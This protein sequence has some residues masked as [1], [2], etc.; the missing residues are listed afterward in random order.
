M[1]DENGVYRFPALPPGTYSVKFELS[2]FRPA[3][4][5]A[6][7]QLGQTITVDARLEP[8][9]V[10]ETVEV[11]GA[12]PVVDVRSSAAQK[13]LT[14]EVLEFIPYSTR[15]GPDAIMLAPGVNPNNLTAYGGGGENSNAYLID[16]VDTQRSGAGQ[17][18]GCSLTTTGSRKSRSSVWA[19]RRNTAALPAWPRTA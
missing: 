5:E 15:F 1:T 7:L 2:G 14:E 16:G 10:T 9:G 18:S 8:G 12:P 17:L 19:R 13:N 6:R 3:T 11:R 4:H